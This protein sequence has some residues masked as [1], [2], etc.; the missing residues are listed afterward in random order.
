[1]AD[2]SLEASP[3][4]APSGALDASTFGVLWNTPAALRA[5]VGGQPDEVLARPNEEGWT[6]K[7]VLSHLLVAEGPPFVDRIRSILAGDD[8][9]NIDEQTLID[10]SGFLERDAG[11]LLRDF[12]RN[13]RQ[14][15][16]WLRTLEPDDFARKATHELAGEVA[17]ADIVHHIAFHDLLHLRQLSEM[18]MP[19]L[20][21]RRG[22]LRMF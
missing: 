22:A 17:I 20:D 9:A 14:S 5:L 8:I 18:L 3:P 19:A 7:H 16:E 13:R 1:V 15:V 6:P 11:A 12:E 2:T 21:E 4:D 10:D